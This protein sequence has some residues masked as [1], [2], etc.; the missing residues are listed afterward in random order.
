MSHDF[1]V[2]TGPS[3]AQR[4]TPSSPSQPGRQTSEPAPDTPTR[5]ARP[6]PVP[7]EPA[8]GS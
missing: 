2:V 4:R 3:M 1:D 6:A 8:A 7:R 5:P